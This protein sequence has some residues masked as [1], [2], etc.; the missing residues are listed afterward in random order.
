MFGLAM[1][2][3]IISLMMSLEIQ[4]STKALGLELSDMEGLN[5]PSIVQY[6]KRKF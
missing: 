6:L 3:F 5:D 1:L 4:L 2:V